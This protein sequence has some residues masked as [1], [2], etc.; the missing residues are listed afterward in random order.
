MIVNVKVKPNSKE[1]RIVKI[2]DGSY[3]VDLTE[4]AEDNKAN[5]E[6]INLL[7]REFNVDFRKIRIK[8]PRSRKK[9][10]EIGE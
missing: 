6:L 10:V 1:E 4:K 8:N 3:E 7:A 5:I 9:I 2:A